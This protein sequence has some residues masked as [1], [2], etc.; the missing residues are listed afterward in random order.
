[1]SLLEKYFQELYYVNKCYQYKDLTYESFSRFEENREYA[2]VLYI[3]QMTFEEIA[4][5]CTYTVFIMSAKMPEMAT[6]FV[7]CINL[8]DMETVN[9][10]ADYA[11]WLQLLEPQ[12]VR[13]YLIYK[14]MLAIKKISFVFFFFGGN[15]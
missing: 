13:E 6:F 8:E 2:L 9:E 7:N 11:A 10:I 4:Q 12:N 14:F 3:K 1:M 5:H 15:G